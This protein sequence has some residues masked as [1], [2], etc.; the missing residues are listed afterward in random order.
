MTNF[1]LLKAMQAILIEHNENPV[2]ANWVFEHYH[3]LDSDKYQITQLYNFPAKHIDQCLTA[4]NRYVSGEPLARI[5]KKATFYYQ[6]FIVNDGVFCPR[7]ETELLVENVLKYCKN[8]SNLNIIDLCCG[9]GIIG[10]SLKL[11]LDPKTQV[12]C[13]DID[14]LAIKNT[15]ANKDKFSCNINVIKSSLFDDVVQTQFNVLVCNPPYIARHEKIDST[16]IKHDPMQAL[17]ADDNG[18]QFYRTI[19]S[20]MKKYL[21]PKYLVAFE[22]G[23][24]QAQEVK[25]LLL[26]YEPSLEIEI[27]QDYN[28]VDRVI[29]ARKG[30]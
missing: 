13:V 17:F 14:N 9:T 22:I 28:K 5:L 6:E 19:I 12:T 26:D 24:T 20:T 23:A 4:I 25:Q 2:V 1:D 18:L 7:V 30:F 29:I 8:K 21:T 11:N 27:I 10:I 3:N 16:V 15:I